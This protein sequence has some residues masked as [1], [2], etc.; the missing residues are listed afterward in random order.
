MRW[1]WR[2][3]SGVGVALGFVRADDCEKRLMS[4]GNVPAEVLG[5]EFS[6]AG[7]LWIAGVTGVTPRLLASPAEV[8]VGEVPLAGA[9]EVTPD[10]PDALRIV[11]PVS[12]KEA[13][14]RR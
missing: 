1:F 9:A 6:P 3:F 10:A 7:E 14:N 5:E 12:A 11:S 2:G 4:F 8:A 13:R